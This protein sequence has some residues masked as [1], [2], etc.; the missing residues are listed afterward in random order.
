MPQAPCVRTDELC[1]RNPKAVTRR[2]DAGEMKAD[3]DR[4]F[5]LSRDWDFP[6]VAQQTHP[7]TWFSHILHIQGARYVSSTNPSMKNGH[8]FLFT[9]TR[10]NGLVS[11]SE[12]RWL[13]PFVVKPQSCICCQSHTR[14]QKLSSWVNSCVT[15]HF[16][17]CIRM[18]LKWRSRCAAHD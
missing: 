3:E 2:V 15:T 5:L 9:R 7:L 14:V 6:P 11:L 1:V 18:L 16:W 12:L 13:S 10:W 17:S 4:R 8:A